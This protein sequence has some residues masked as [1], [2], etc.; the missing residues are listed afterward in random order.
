MALAA[1]GALVALGLGTILTQSLVTGAGH[2]GDSGLADAE[3]DAPA[4]FASQPLEDQVRELLAETEEAPGTLS[5]LEGAAADESAASPES[6]P[7]DDAGG[8]AATDEYPL[9]TQSSPP[10]SQ[11]E[12]ELVAQVPSCVE[13]AIGRREA[14]LAAEAE[15]YGGVDAYLVVFRHAADPEQVDAYVVDA[16]CV[17]ATP[18]ASGEILAQRSYPLE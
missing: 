12:G 16:D 6:S 3:M 11:E 2:G 9:E 7:E 17:S 8:D 18:P 4:E 1:A 5:S 14:P 10:A 13:D 15:D